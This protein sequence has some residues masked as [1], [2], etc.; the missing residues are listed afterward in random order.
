MNPEDEKEFEL[1]LAA[2]NYARPSPKEYLKQLLDKQ[3]ARHIEA[4]EELRIGID[5]GTSQGDEGYLQAID[6]YQDA[7]RKER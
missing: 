4:G 6:D 2:G 3:K 1:I 7:I 5:G